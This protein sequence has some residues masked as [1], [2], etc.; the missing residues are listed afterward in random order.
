[1]VSCLDCRKSETLSDYM[2]VV[3]AVF[4]CVFCGC[5]GINKIKKGWIYI[6]ERR[7]AIMLYAKGNTGYH[8][9]A[10]QLQRKNTSILNEEMGFQH[11]VGTK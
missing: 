8:I 2:A 7:Y 6:M 11:P 5:L 9:S 10:V 1:M 4:F 3:L